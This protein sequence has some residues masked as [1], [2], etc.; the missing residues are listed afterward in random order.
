MKFEYA[1]GKFTDKVVEIYHISDDNAPTLAIQNDGSSEFW[2]F[3]RACFNS[4]TG[5]DSPFT[6][7][8]IYSDAHNRGKGGY[9]PIYDDTWIAWSEG[10]TMDAQVLSSD[11]LGDFLISLEAQR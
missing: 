11:E 1:E 10:M 9:E 7:I 4:F 2:D 3:A 5:L 8:Y 6:T